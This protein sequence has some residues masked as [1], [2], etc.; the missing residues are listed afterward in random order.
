MVRDLVGRADIFV[1]GQQTHFAAL[2][3]MNTRERSGKHV[4]LD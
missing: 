1:D 3:H 2:W 4:T